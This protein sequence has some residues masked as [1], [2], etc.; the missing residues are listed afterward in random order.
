MDKEIQEK[1]VAKLQKEMLDL[2]R[3]KYKIELKAKETVQE[4]KKNQRTTMNDVKGRQ[5]AQ[6]NVE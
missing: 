5:T 2:D 3:E 6:S 1:K 4:L